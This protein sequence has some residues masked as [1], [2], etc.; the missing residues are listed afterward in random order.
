MF[1]FKTF[2]LILAAAATIV[3]A[4]PTGTN[5][6]LVKRDAAPAPVPASAPVARA[7]NAMAMP[8][9]ARGG[10]PTPSSVPDCISKCKDTI[11]PIFV[12]IQAAVDAQA[13]VSVFVTLWLEVLVAIQQLTVDITALLGA[14]VDILAGLTVSACASLFADLLLSIAVQLKA[15]VGVI[16]DVS[17]FVDVYTQICLA[18]V[19]SVQAI[20]KVV[21]GINA[22]LLVDLVA[23][24]D[25][26]VQLCATVGASADV[27]AALN[28]LIGL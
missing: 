26:L 19:A 8:V 12:N 7:A 17:A 14:S 10:T 28:A 23:C 27:V 24:V 13:D 6:E 21:V 5:A 9:V 1:G 18:I 2:A 3:T 15:S 22:F 4:I 20:V 25:I 11:T 16:V